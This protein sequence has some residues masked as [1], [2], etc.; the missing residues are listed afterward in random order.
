M[1]MWNM[2]GKLVSPL[3]N[4][5]VDT[6]YRFTFYQVSYSVIFLLGL[7]ANSLA[8]R[9]LL[10]SPCTMNSTGIYMAS[11]STADLF[12]IISLP[13]RIY[14][15]HQKAQ[16]LSSKTDNSSSWTSGAAYCHITFTLKYISLYG[17]I[18]FLVCIAVDRYLAV[19]HPWAPTLRR[20]RV[21]QVVSVGIW[22]L[23]LGLSVSLPLLRSAASSQNKPCLLDPSS[24]RHQTTILA[25][26]GLVLGFFLLPTL[27]LLYSYCRVLSVLRHYINR[28][29]RR[30]RQH[31]LRVI[32]WV[33]GVY[34]LCFLPYHI[35]LLV[36]TLTHMNLLPHCGLA[37]VTKAVQPVV[38]SL[39]SSNCCL[40]PLIY[41]FSSSLVHRE[42]PG[43]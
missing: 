36:Y 9:R 6:S 40:N 8:L 28:S 12:F 30:N 34:L 2:T 13:M 35:N 42:L 7:P 29:H 21:A 18:F 19:V 39:A 24:R 37:K 1:E 27:V 15:Y 32:Y 3:S 43:G 20:L 10:S 33:L 16:A 17:G 26:L 4:C 14:Y 41:Y 23:V 38:L 11:L 22:C 25:I 5:T 31:T